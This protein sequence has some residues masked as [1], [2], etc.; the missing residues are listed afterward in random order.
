MMTMAFTVSRK[1]RLNKAEMEEV[2]SIMM[3]RVSS[4]CEFE[5]DED[6]DDDDSDDAA[7]VCFLFDHCD[8]VMLWG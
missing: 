8:G 7:G 6:D 1:V 3:E 5:H 4:W 2:G